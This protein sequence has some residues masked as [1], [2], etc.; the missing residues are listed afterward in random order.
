MITHRL[1]IPLKKCL[2]CSRWYWNWWFWHPL[3]WRH[4]CPEFCSRDCADHDRLTLEGD[5]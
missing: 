2:M 5:E 4:G 3:T 1:P